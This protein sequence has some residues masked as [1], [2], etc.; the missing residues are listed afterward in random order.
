MIVNITHVHQHKETGSNETHTS[1]ESSLQVLHIKIL[2][3]SQK[4]L[5]IE[6]MGMHRKG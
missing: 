4:I 1:V 2:N 6:F 3:R 5:V